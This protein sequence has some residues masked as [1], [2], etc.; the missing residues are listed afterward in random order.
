MDWSICHFDAFSHT[1]YFIHNFLRV[2]TPEGRRGLPRPWKRRRAAAA[3]DCG[4]RPRRPQLPPR[5]PRQ[6]RRLTPGA[7][8]CGAGTPGGGA[9]VCLSRIRSAAPP[10]RRPPA[11]SGSGAAP[12]KRRGRGPCHRGLPRRPVKNAPGEARTPNNSVR[13]S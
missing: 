4:S 1:K 10:A 9:S 8:R 2:P 6:R 7:R 3:P 5:P 11:G 12:G 13:G